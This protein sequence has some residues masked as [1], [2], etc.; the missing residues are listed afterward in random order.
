MRARRLYIA[1]FLFAAF[2]MVSQVKV[3]KPVK[4]SKPKTTRLSFY[5]GYSSSEL[6]LERNIQEDNAAHGYHLGASY[7]LT[8]VYR[9]CFEYTNYSKI[10]IAPTWFNINAQTFEFNVHA[11]AKMRGAPAF[12]YPVMGMSYNVFEGYFTGERDY[13]HLSRMYEKNANVK[14]TWVGANLGLGLE[15]FIK[16]VSLYA[17]FKMRMGITESGALS[18]MDVCFSTGIRYNLRVPSLYKMFSGTRSR[19]LLD[20]RESDF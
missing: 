9:A 2:S 13:L 11:L 16:P 20:T 3:I 19:Y 1:I 14:T 18:V 6:L 10:N 15:Y 5:G 7:G 4:K 12:F 8:R 17:E